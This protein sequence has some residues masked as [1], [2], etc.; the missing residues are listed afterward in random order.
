[1][2]M[3]VDNHFYYGFSDIYKIPFKP[4][5][6]YDLG[7]YYFQNGMFVLDFQVMFSK[8]N[9]QCIPSWEEKIGSSVYFNIPY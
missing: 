9:I 7:G 4:L 1:M 5:L 8:E 3:T 2:N 6:E